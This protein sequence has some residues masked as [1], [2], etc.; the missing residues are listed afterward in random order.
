[1]WLSGKRICL[2]TQEIQESWRHR[3]NPWVRKTPWNRKWQHTAVFLP[4]KFDRGVWWA[5]ITSQT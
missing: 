2:P 3:F 5:E 1:M 4:G